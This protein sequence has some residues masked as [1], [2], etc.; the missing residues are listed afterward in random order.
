MCRRVPVFL[1]VFMA[2]ATAA[3]AAEFSDQAVQNAIKRGVDYL[4][5]TQQPNG[6]W[7]TKAEQGNRTGRTAL[8][9]YALLESGMDPQNDRI[10][11]ALNWVGSRYQEETGTY[12]LGLRGVM[13]EAAN[14][15]AN[16]LF[17]KVLYHDARKLWRST[18]TGSYDYHSKGLT[19]VGRWDNS[20]SQ[21]G[22]LGVW[23]AD[24]AHIEVP[25][26]YWVKVAKHWE[27]CQNAD[28]GWSYTKGESTAAMT[29]G[30]VASLFVAYDHVYREHFATC[31]RRGYGPVRKGIDW[32]DKNFTQTLAGRQLGHSDM[33]YY[34]YG[35]ERVGLASGY[36]HFGK[37]DWYK[38]GAEHLLSQQG[39]DGSWTGKWG[40]EVGTSY[41]L[42][43][44][45]RGRNAILFNKL[46]FDG[47]WNNRPRDMANLAGWLSRQFERTLNWQI[48]NLTAPVR[49]WDDAPIV[50]ISGSRLPKF[51]DEQVAKL[52][53]YVLQG[54]SIVSVTECGGVAGFKKGIRDLYTRMFP[55][56]QL[57][58][59]P[60]T[61]EIYS[62][63]VHF[64]LAGAAGIS[65][66]GDQVRI[67]SGGVILRTPAKETS[68]LRTRK[69]PR[70]ALFMLS[71]GVRALAIHTDED[72]SLMWQLKRTVSQKWAFWAG[73][74]IVRYFTG[75]IDH[76]RPRGV[77]NWPQPHQG[78]AGRTAKIV[79]LKHAG[80]YDPE[81]LAY[82][83]FARLMATRASANVEVAA[84][85]DI[86]DL[87]ASGAKLATLT[88]TGTLD[89]SQA[90]MAA[91]KEFVKGGGLVA[92]DAAG[93][94]K[95]FADSA[96]ATVRKLFGPLS[97]RT[98]AASASLYTQPGR[99]IP[100][101]KYRRRTRMR[102]TRKST[103]N[104]KAVLV[105]DRVGVLLS[106]E[107]ITAGLVGYPSFA[108]DGYD[109]ETAFQLMRNIVLS[110]H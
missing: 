60:P 27:S 21:Y 80:N 54:G 40:G 77:R 62:R 37:V 19:R 99:A 35:V 98:L 56:Y 16:G 83:R 89:L 34:L 12:S 48:I 85:I 102:L 42:L 29:A 8:A 75:T 100:K 10:K 55:K 52:R 95:D 23:A 58:P 82:E 69:G 24:L 74:N 73:T 26:A 51:T 92:I 71:N 4:L 39:G 97:L 47:D 13:W 84:P 103:P 20:N 81:P 57:T 87:P 9:T 3:R 78:G 105:G 65:L 30:G 43:F 63:K 17:R 64:D 50:Y 104:I 28:G 2:A 14:R 59:C 22:L 49:E 36:K 107:D 41:A 96:E 94:C 76:V 106:R 53:T 110:V 86:K 72:M 11:K 93:G 25:D 91:L 109:P 90:E 88:G 108:V 44:L 70:P 68:P 33:Y 32:I 61:H 18:V 15:R 79:R 31:G 66:P 67:L 5:K 46:Q 7:D 6:S 1:S 101:V 45:V 38:R